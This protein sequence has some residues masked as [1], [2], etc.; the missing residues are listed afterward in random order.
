MFSSG[1]H[2]YLFAYAMQRSR[3][4]YESVREIESIQ[5]NTR[6]RAKFYEREIFNENLIYSQAFMLNALLTRKANKKIEFFS[7]S[8]FPLFVL[9]SPPKTNEHKTNFLSAFFQNSVRNTRIYYNDKCTFC[10]WKM[11]C[12]SQ[13]RLT[14]R[15]RDI[16]T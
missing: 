3:F 12:L 11:K 7:L 13:C 15:A 10:S 6:H 5:E 14:K 16:E 1:I 2:A 9:L 4:K 8:S